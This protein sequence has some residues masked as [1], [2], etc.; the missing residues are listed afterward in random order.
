MG[1]LKR[2][3]LLFIVML[4]E[5]NVFP[6]THFDPDVKAKVVC[7]KFNVTVVDFFW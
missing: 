5:F 6:F 1:G 4:Y 2:K 7:G 3:K